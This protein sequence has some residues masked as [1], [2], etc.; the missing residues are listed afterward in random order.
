MRLFFLHKSFLGRSRVRLWSDSRRES[1]SF[2]P[3]HRL[4][5]PFL[6]LT[7]PSRTR[8]TPVH[9]PVLDQDFLAPLPDVPCC[10]KG[11]NAQIPP[12]NFD[13]LAG[14]IFFPL[15]PASLFFLTRPPLWRI[16]QLPLLFSSSNRVPDPGCPFLET[17][18]N[19]T[20]FSC[21]LLSPFGDNLSSFLRD[22]FD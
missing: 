7:F 19:T 22:S 15:P 5:P 13:T 6:D 20:L 18:A 2:F 12:S 17:P 10:F 14:T 1:K 21:L 16:G 4:E 11:L 8:H 3:P 9:T